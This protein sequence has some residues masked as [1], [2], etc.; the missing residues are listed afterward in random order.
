MGVPEKR[1]VHFGRLVQTGSNDRHM[2]IWLHD[3]L[4]YQSEH[5]QGPERFE[6]MHCGRCHVRWAVQ[7]A[8]GRWKEERGQAKEGPALNASQVKFLRNLH[9]GEL[10]EPA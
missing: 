9:W 8:G 3:G 6:C 4:L 7:R 2:E 10:R 5:C 1:C